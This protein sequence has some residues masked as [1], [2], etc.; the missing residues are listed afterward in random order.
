MYTN[1]INYL[2]LSW[3]QIGNDID[4]EQ[5][6]TT[7]DYSVSLSSDGNTVAI[8][9]YGNDGNGSYAGHVVMFVFIILV[10]VT[11]QDVLIH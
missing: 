11:V 6:V 8:G 5:L 3:T 2:E 10:V 4:G 9:A 1:F 7:G